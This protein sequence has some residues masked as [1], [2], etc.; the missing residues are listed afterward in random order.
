MDTRFLESLLA[1]V[2]HGSIVAALQSLT[3][4]AVSQRIQVLERD[5]GVPLFDRKPTR[6]VSFGL[7]R[8]PRC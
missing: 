6:K 4:A 7:M 2:R 5:L 8:S 1:V 3:L